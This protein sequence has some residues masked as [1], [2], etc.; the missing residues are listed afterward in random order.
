MRIEA[1]R[2]EI[3][4]VALLRVAGGAGADRL[5]AEQVSARAHARLRA[6]PGREAHAARRDAPQ[7]VDG[8]VLLE[9]AGGQYDETPIV[10]EREADGGCEHGGGLPAAGRGLEQQQL[11]LGERA[12]DARHDLGLAGPQG[13]EGK[14]DRFRRAAGGGARCVAPL[15]GGER[16]IERGEQ[17]ALGVLHSELDRLADGRRSAEEDQLRAHRPAS[18]APEHACVECG[19]EP[20]ALG[21]PVAPRGRGLQLLDPPARAFDADAVGPAA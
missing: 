12:F 19:L 1:V 15:E 21:R 17:S 16:G 13:G 14:A 9:R 11:A 4:R 20:P 6:Q 8:E 5:V 3:A 2:H 18:R 10:G 7:R